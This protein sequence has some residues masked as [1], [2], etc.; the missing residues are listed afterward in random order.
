MVY[1]MLIITPILV[2]IVPVF[3]SRPVGLTSAIYTHI[4]FLTIRS[5]IIYYLVKEPINDVIYTVFD[6][7]YFAFIFALVISFCITYIVS[8]S[9]V[10]IR[11]INICEQPFLQ[12]CLIYI[13]MKYMEL[14]PS[15]PWLVL[16]T[17]AEFLT[18]PELGPETWVELFEKRRQI[19]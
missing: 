10:F 1:L 14:R 16:I 12:S 7:I 6:N 17:R 5:I 18:A 3:F 19:S 9:D 2:T 15:L 4:S 13:N 8:I 11:E